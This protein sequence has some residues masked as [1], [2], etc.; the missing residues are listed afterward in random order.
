MCLILGLVSLFVKNH[1]H[2]VFES[3]FAIFHEMFETLFYLLFFI[4]GCVLAKYRDEIK[5]VFEKFQNWQ[6]LILFLAVLGLY[7]LNWEL[8]DIRNLALGAKNSTYV[9]G[10]A[11]GLASILMI[12]AALSFER[13]QKIL[14]FKIFLW[15]GKVSY[16]LYLTHVVVLLASVYFLPQFIPLVVRVIFGACFSFVVAGLSYRYLEVPSNSIGHFL[17]KK[18]D[19]KI[20]LKREKVL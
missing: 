19:E 14:H 8:H 2:G 17:A 1:F 18:T 20:F 16:S 13:M 7:N 12:G 3:H 10:C 9:L 5:E 4:F 15:L 11:G 6:K